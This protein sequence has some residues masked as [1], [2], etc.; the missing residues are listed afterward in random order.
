MRKEQKGFVSIVVLLA[1]TLVVAGGVYFVVANG[2]DSDGNNVDKIV[3]Q[4]TQE[5]INQANSASSELLNNGA[6]PALYTQYGLPEYPGATLTYDGRT[7][8]NLADGISLKLTTSDG[9]QMVGAFYASAFGSLA[10][11]DFTPPN[12][13][14]DTL[15]GATATKSDENLRY[16]LTVTKLPDETQISISFL[17]N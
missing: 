4:A 10:G 15:Y 12:F 1:V 13:S 5:Q 2:N 8:D 11:W 14:N 17:Q 7:A 6:Y 9:V 16:Q 3:A